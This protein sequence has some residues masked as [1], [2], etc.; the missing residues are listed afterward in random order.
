MRKEYH[1]DPERNSA[2]KGQKPLRLSRMLPEPFRQLGARDISKPKH[3]ARNRNESADSNSFKRD[4]SSLH[5][6]DHHPE[7]EQLNDGSST[8]KAAHDTYGVEQRLLTFAEV[9]LPAK[10]S[11]LSAEGHHAPLRP[12]A[13]A[14]NE[15][16]K[17]H[18]HTNRPSPC[19]GK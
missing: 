2:S 18:R 8:D 11:E 14:H 7:P 10:D 5:P 19:E 4:W 15:S 3:P 16:D 9:P 12:G 1:R 6:G 13:S 17:A